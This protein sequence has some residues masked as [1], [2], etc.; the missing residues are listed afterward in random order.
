MWSSVAA[1]LQEKAWPPLGISS[2]QLK[3]QKTALEFLAVLEEKS[4]IGPAP[5]VVPG[6]E[7]EPEPVAECESEPV[8]GCE[9]EP[10][11]ECVELGFVRASRPAEPPFV[12]EVRPA[13]AVPAY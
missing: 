8:A 5:W 11:A 2:G 9:P 3:D 1:T 4:E 10:V 13:V 7:C 12:L 6:A